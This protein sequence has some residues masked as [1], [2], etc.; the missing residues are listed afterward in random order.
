MRGWAQSLG[1]QNLLA[2]L[3]DPDTGLNHVA[4]EETPDG[5]RNWSEREWERN[6]DHAKRHSLTFLAREFATPSWRAMSAESVGL[7]EITYPGLDAIEPPSNF[8]GDLPNEEVRQ[9]VRACWSPLLH[10]LCD[11]L[12]LEGVITLGEKEADLTY[13][14]GGVPIGRWSAKSDV[15]NHGLLRFVGVGPDQRRRRFA[16]AVLRACGLSKEDASR[17]G[18]ELLGVAFDQ[19]FANAA[20]H[21]QTPT[22][23]EFAW[24]EKHDGKQ[25]KDG[26]PAA[27]LRLVFP[28]LGL[29]RP[30]ALFQC[31]RTGHVWCRSVQGCAPETGAVSNLRPVTDGA[32]DA[33]PRLGRVRREY[34]E[35]PVF[36]IGLWAEEHSA[37]LAPKE[38]RR[39]QDLFRAGIRN[40]LSATTTLELGIDIGGLTAVLTSNVP[41]GKANYLQRGARTV[42]RL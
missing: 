37:Q 16:A 2:E 20:S 42:H 34:R 28:N 3:L 30:P 31:E 22:T 23:G 9:A 7:A 26:P 38:N 21:G 41:P 5:L 17:F 27:A 13:R 14:T 40:V 15:G 33:D 32:L 11:T 4:R 25:T 1:K 12:R 29:R 6:W 19:L 10:A 24:V 39:L 36:R 8:I 18:T 35:S